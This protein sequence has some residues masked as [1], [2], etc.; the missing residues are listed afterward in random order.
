VH[1]LDA[2]QK[3]L[4][5]VPAGVAFSTPQQP[6]VFNRETSLK[7][8]SKRYTV[9]ALQSVFATGPVLPAVL[10]TFKNRAAR[11]FLRQFGWNILAAVSQ[12]KQKIINRNGVIPSLPIGM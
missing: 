11:I 7:L 9:A 1:K 4:N 8:I 2:V 5:I 3:S 12:K 6:A 10:E